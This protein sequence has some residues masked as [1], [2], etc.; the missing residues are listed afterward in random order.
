MML[1]NSLMEVLMP[2]FTEES[3]EV[4]TT[5]LLEEIKKLPELIFKLVMHLMVL[6]SILMPAESLDMV[7]E[8]VDALKLMLQCKVHTWLLFKASKVLTLSKL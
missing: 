6:L 3:Q 2:H 4:Q 7:E 1:F 8:A 5:L